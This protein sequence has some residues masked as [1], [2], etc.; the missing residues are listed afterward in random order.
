M[1]P[2]IPPFIFLIFCNRT[3]VKKISKCPPFTVS[4]S[5]SAPLYPIFVFFR[6]RCFFYATFFSNL[7]SSKPQ[8]LLE[9]KR[10]ASIKHCSRFSALCDL[11]ETFIK[12]NFEKFRKFP[13]QF[14]VFFKGL[15][16]RKMVFLLFPLGEELFSRFMGIPS[17]FF[18]AV[19]LMKF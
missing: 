16:L 5:Q 17:G 6:D 9:T 18:G 11:P 14:S 8:F 19:K 10:F 1:S 3:Y 12:K 4:Q 7:F 15:R 2:K 13:P